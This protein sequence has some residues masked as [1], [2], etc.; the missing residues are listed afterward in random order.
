M[1]K[2]EYWKEVYS[3]VEI[4]ISILSQ[5]AKNKTKKKN[6]EKKTE[7]NYVKQ[8]SERGRIRSQ[9]LSMYVPPKV[10]VGTTT[11]G[12][13]RIKNIKKNK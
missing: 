11:Q 1:I 7:L 12:E 9:L 5:E 8:K 3:R 4:L 2:E 13:H 6:N 10:R